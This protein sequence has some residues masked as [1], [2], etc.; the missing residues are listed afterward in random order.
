M[1]GPSGRTYYDLPGPLLND[2][3]V[4]WAEDGT[5]LWNPDWNVNVGVGINAQFIGAVNVVLQNGHEYF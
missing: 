1:K 5:C 2:E 4:R 3:E